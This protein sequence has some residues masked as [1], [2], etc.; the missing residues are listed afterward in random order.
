MVNTAARPAVQ[1][2]AIGV[3]SA[4][5]ISACGHGNLG[6]A[7]RTDQ[8][9][10]NV[11]VDYEFAIQQAPQSYKDICATCRRT[12]RKLHHFSVIAA[13]DKCCRICLSG[14]TSRITGC[15]I[16]AKNQDPSD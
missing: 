15:E 10:I 2:V 6:L 3:H 16:D 11:N 5:V 7:D 14:I 4:Y 8:R 1:R 13:G 9:V 12:I